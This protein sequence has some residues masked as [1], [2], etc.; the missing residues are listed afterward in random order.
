[1]GKQDDL[2]KISSI[3]EEAAEYGLEAEVIYEAL[4]IMQEDPSITPA[5]AVQLG[6]DEW[7]K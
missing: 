2:R 7:V 3:L 1:M 5:Q 6:A 4:K